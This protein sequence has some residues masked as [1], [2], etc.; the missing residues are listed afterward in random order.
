LGPVFGQGELSA[1]QPFN[2]ENNCYSFANCD[3]FH[4]PFDFDCRSNLTNLKCHEKGESY[5]SEFTI[6]EIEV[7]EVIFEK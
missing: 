2:G 1:L 6:S 3:G 5:V 4:I 7:W